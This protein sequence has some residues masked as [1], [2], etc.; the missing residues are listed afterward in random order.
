MVLYPRPA[1]AASL[2]PLAVS[3]VPLAASLVPL[4]ASVVLLAASIV[5][6]AIDLVLF[7]GDLVLLTVGPVRLAEDHK[8]FVVGSAALAV[9]KGLLQA[10]KVAPILRLLTTPGD[11]KSLA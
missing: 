5:P 11:T 1:L 3:V 10:L 4:A 6:L 8:V 9:G 7:T 2:V